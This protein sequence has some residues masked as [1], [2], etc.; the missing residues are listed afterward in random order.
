MC[1][2]GDIP[3]E[4]GARRTMDKYS[5]R[6][7]IKVVGIDLAKS[8]FHLHGVDEQG[9]VVMRRKLSRS[10]LAALMVNLPPCLVGMEACGGSHDW[11]RKLM[12]MGHDVRLMSPQFVK[13]Y[14]KS[15]KN[16]MVDAEA[17]CEAVQRPN[18][19]FVPIKGIEQQDIQSLHRARSLA[20]SHRTSQVNQIRGLLLEYGLTV[21]KGVASLRKALPEILEDA[22]NGL[23]PMFREL[24]SSLAEELR[25]LDERIAVY[26]AQIRQLSEQSD[27][28]QRLMTIPGVG[29]MTA[30][31]LV[32]AIAD[33]KVFKSGREMSA[34]LGL[35]PRQYSTGGKPRLLGISK[36]GDT[37]LRKLLIHGARA[38]L[39]FADRKQDRRSRWV[40]EVEGRRGRN[41]AAVA[42]ANK[43][44]RTAW[45]LLSKGED[46]K[47][48]VAVW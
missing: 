33:A 23:S 21:A 24:L 12:A 45:V 38:A 39:R 11:A 14:V 2:N 36:R 47:T 22:D 6:E 7:E 40:V 28:C 44:V 3:I 5:E 10:K 46:Y 9:H 37:Y 1:Q 30:T 41:I 29:P 43:T 27:A 13:P 18:M 42:L 31:A 26:D 35:V 25:R 16:D 34:W 8:M 4:E 17:I 20:V 32:A 15:N 19:R 48:A